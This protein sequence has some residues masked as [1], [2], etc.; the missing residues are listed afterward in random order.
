MADA[1]RLRVDVSRHVRYALHVLNSP[2]PPAAAALDAMRATVVYFALHALDVCA[3]LPSLAPARRAATAAWLHACLAPGGGGFAGSPGAQHAHVACTYAALCGLR[4]LGD[5]LARVPR[6]RAAAL[7]A[8][9]QV[10]GGAD[11][12]GVA[13]SRACAEEV[14]VR[15][16]YSAAAVCA[17]LDLPAAALDGAAALRYLRGCQ[18]HEGGFALARGGGEAHGASTYCAVAA[19][20]LLR[21]RQRRSGGGGGGGG[22]GGDCSDGLDLVALQRWLALRAEPS[23]G[24]S[25]RAGKDADVCYTWW[26]GAAARILREEEEAAGGSGGGGGGASCAPAGD[27]AVLL[28]WLESCR[29]SGGAGYGK[30]AE[31]EA[32]PFHTAFALAGMGVLGLGG[33]ASVDAALGLTPRAL[34]STD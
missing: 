14:D 5:D 12:G 2:A 25:G 9:L 28:A 3:A 21:R 16:L 10:A 24:V 34:A 7:L 1:A 30:D 22:G 31:A 20:A 11:A 15:F 33:L 8:A 17:L 18:T 32:D 27:P 29:G 6:A 4:I 19:W 26:V 13:S 23:G